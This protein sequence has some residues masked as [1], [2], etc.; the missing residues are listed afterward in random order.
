MQSPQQTRELA[1]ST[2]ELQPAV[3]L[4]HECS[5]PACAEDLRLACVD[6]IASSGEDADV[7][8]FSAGTAHLAH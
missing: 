6:A 3:E 8:L 2:S 7:D 5:A 1:E 4:L